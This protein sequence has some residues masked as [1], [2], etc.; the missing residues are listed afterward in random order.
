MGQGTSCA[1]HSAFLTVAMTTE[2]KASFVAFLANRGMLQRENKKRMYDILAV[3]IW[4]QNRDEST[5]LDEANHFRAH[6]TMYFC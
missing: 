6:S 1:H 2:H 5:T 3:L 4:K